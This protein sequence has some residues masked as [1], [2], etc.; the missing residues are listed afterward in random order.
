MAIL[1]D[2]HSKVLVQGI[3]GRE[4]AFHAAR[5]LA[6]GPPWWWAPRRARAARRWPAYRRWLR[7]RAV[8]AS[9]ATVS[10]IFVPA[11]LAED[12]ILEAADAGL[13]LV[14]CITEG[15]AVRD[16]SRRP[17]SSNGG[18]YASS[19]RIARGWSRRAANVGIMPADIFRAGPVGLVSRSGTLTYLIV[20]ELS[21]AGLGQSSCVGIVG[22]AVHGLG[23]IGCL[24]RFEADPRPQRWF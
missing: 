19:G 8:A 21:R 4:G 24:Q 14:V 17:R 9:G 15:I 16:T 23:F 7:C 10:L 5:M 13:G 18:P 22:D 1:V 12:A 11:R 2:E 3:T 6:A 20:S